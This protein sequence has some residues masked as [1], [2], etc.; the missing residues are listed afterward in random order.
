[1]ALL[2]TVLL[3]LS[4]AILIYFLNDFSRQDFIR[5]T[6]AA[7]D[8][9]ISAMLAVVDE[10][11][12]A[13][14]EAYVRQRVKHLSYARFIYT[15]ADGKPLAGDAWSIPPDVKP[16]A[17]GVLR[18]SIATPKGAM[19]LAAKIHTFP[20]NSRVIVARDI[21]GLIASYARLKWLSFV[22]MGLMLAVVL[23]SF[24]ISFFVVGRIN[25]IAEIA[26][27]IMVTGDL[28]QRISV[29]TKWDD[30][31]NLAD[32]LNGFL[33]RIEAL[34]QGIREVS[35]SIAHDLRT[36]LTSLRHD[37]ETLKQRLPEEP[38]IDRLL[39]EAD[40]LLALFQSLLRITSLEQGRR[41]QAFTR[42]E[43]Q[44]LLQ[45]VIE[46]YEPLAEE[47]SLCL[48]HAFQ[49]AG[50]IDGDADLL[51][52][53]FT[54]LVDNAIKFSPAGGEV[55]LGL[56]RRGSDLMVSVEDQ[57]PGIPESEKENVFR[58]FYRGDAS[59]STPGHG[60]G[61]SLAKAVVEMH[62]GRIELQDNLPGLRVLVTFLPYQ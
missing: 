17:E 2:F 1:M 23:V 40:R 13:S 42:L 8:A 52:Q 46:L 41:P 34:M 10:H 56:A 5:E 25:L 11:D 53:L 50:I 21:Q 49:D 24:A 35:S 45:D 37:I 33:E 15:D 29:E 57:G 3:G 47:R 59:R 26:Q 28:S 38:E 30:L 18:F 22:I 43:M 27:R 32:V 36:P 44:K 4:A 62:H 39:A 12:P 58:H 48:Q 61:L 55:T 54:N 60:L 14:I 7:I 9:E 31:S 20:D 51:F 16:L 19:A 6:E